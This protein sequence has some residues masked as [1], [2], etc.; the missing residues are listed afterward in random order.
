MKTIESPWRGAL[1]KGIRK[2]SKKSLKYAQ[3]FFFKSYFTFYFDHWSLVSW[4][5]PRYGGFYEYLRVEDETRTRG[6]TRNGTKDFMDCF[7]V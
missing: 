3:F 7:N 2:F 1:K 4:F 5:H 6:V